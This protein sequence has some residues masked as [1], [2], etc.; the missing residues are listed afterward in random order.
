VLE[1]DARETVKQSQT[2]LGVDDHADLLL[3]FHD[4]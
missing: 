4:S 1:N 2:F 3:F